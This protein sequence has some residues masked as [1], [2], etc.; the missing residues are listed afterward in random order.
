MAGIAPQ[1]LAAESPG[2]RA[3]LNCLSRTSGP[4]SRRRPRAASTAS[5]DLRNL[6]HRSSRPAPG[7]VRHTPGSR[8]PG[9]RALYLLFRPSARGIGGRELQNEAPCPR[10]ERKA[11]MRKGFRTIAGCRDPCKS[12]KTVSGREGS[13]KRGPVPRRGHARRGCKGSRAISGAGALRSAVKRGPP[14]VG[15]A[16]GRGAWARATISAWKQKKMPLVI[17]ILLQQTLSSQS[18]PSLRPLHT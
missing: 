1:D 9:F 12:P 8:G 4:R 5:L 2:L 11:P 13:G 6:T 10:S 15:V 17:T 18:Q 16:R 7:S 14:R 3:R